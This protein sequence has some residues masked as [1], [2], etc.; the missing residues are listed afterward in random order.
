M[1]PS[2]R[3][4]AGLYLRIHFT[5]QTEE[6]QKLGLDKIISEKSSRIRNLV[7]AMIVARI[8]NP[9]SKLATAR[10]FN[11][12]TYSQSLGQLLDLE[13]ADEDELYN[14][15]DWLL[16]KQEKIEK[17]LALKHLESGTLVLYD[18]TS[19]YLEAAILILRFHDIKTLAPRG[20]NNS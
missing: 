18:V 5:H 14:A 11:S 6:S 10:G 3:S 9:K 4:P 15:L 2:T 12:E 1:V 7:V 13:K 16:E 19:A 20:V 8:I 17:H